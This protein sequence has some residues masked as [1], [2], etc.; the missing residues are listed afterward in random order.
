MLNCIEIDNTNINDD[1]NVYELLKQVGIR[2]SIAKLEKLAKMGGLRIN[3]EKVD[4]GNLKL[5]S[6]PAL[7]GCLYVIKSGKK[8]YFSLLVK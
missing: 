2:P 5:S 1:T 8:E 6:Y 7:S 4:P 3:N